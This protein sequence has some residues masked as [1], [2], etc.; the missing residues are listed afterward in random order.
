M[1]RAVGRGRLTPLLLVACLAVGGG[2]GGTCGAAGRAAPGPWR[3]RL[4]GG[5]G[6]R[7]DARDSERDRVVTASILKRLAQKDGAD[8]SD[9]V[10]KKGAKTKKKA[11]SRADRAEAGGETFERDGLEF[12]RDINDDAEHLLREGRLGE[13][14]LERAREFMDSDEIDNWDALYEDADADPASSGREAVERVRERLAAASS[15]KRAVAAAAGDAQEKRRAGQLKEK[16]KGKE[17]GPWHSG[18]ASREATS[19]KAVS[20]NPARYQEE[21]AVDTVLGLQVLARALR[22][23]AC[24]LA[25]AHALVLVNTG[26]TKESGLWGHCGY[27]HVREL[28]HS[29]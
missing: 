5:G 11:G 18:G 6:G 4:R 29:T 12:R 16:R 10:R 3:L 23:C 17:Q 9:G 19:G 27:I 28:M 15:A 26:H 25:L 14:P 20:S 24:A 21:G 8:A 7:G 13:D 2:A 1:H 22:A